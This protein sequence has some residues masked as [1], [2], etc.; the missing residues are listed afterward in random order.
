MFFFQATFRYS[1]KETVIDENSGRKYHQILLPGIG[2]VNQ[3]MQ[4][5]SFCM[6]NYLTDKT[7]LRIGNCDFSNEPA[8]RGSMAQVVEIGIRSLPVDMPK[9]IIASHT[10]RGPK[11]LIFRLESD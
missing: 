2:S 6:E 9:S 5:S 11:L 3:N 7:A 4:N 1:M 8:A 10:N